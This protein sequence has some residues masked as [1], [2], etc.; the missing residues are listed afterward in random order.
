VA[1]PP[2][3][4]TP[5]EE[6]E[7]DGP[8]PA[9]GEGVDDGSNIGS[10]DHK[11]IDGFRVVDLKEELRKRKLPLDGNKAVLVKRLKEACPE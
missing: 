5:A 7:G 6:E 4:E 3:E 11:T 10:L 2:P 9:D 1:P 8:P